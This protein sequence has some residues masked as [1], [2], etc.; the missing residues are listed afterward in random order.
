MFKVWA[1]SVTTLR[2]MMRER[3]FFV[4]IFLAAALLGLSFLL[5]ALSFAEQ[6]RIITDFGFLAMQVALLGVSLFSGSYLISKE[7]EKQ[8]CLLILS[9]PVT[10]GQFILGKL[11]GVAALNTLLMGSL[12][13]L[14]CFL[15]G[16]W[17]SSA[18]IWW[19][20]FEIVLSLWLESLVVLCLV[21]AMSMI[22]RPVL[23]LGGGTIV[24]LLGHWLGDL[25]FFAQKSQQ[26]FFISFVRILHWVTPNFYK[27]NW[28]SASFLDAGVP[29]QNFIWMLAHMTGW[30]VL[31]I[32]I[33][34]F[35]FRRK[36]IV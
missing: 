26:E 18:Q 19:T 20:F 30:I 29:V 5:G 34:I 4:V 36:D 25:A 21:I 3:V 2:E 27:M 6:R 11:F 32:L 22:V 28:K 1:L 35:F 8:T 24:F 31:L 23:A 14:L 12:G 15:L 33:A 17:T 7:V 10:R 13:L 9:R 16:L